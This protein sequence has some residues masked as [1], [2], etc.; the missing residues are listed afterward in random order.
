MD[1]KDEMDETDEIDEPDVFRG[2]P[3]FFPKLEMHLK[4]GQFSYIVSS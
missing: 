3:E 2:S 4:L 1:E